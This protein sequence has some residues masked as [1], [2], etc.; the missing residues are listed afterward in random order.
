[1]YRTA[2][3]AEP[4][5]AAPPASAP[6]ARGASCSC[7]RRSSKERRT[8]RGG[9]GSYAEL[10]SLQKSNDLHFFA[11]K[12]RIASL[13]ISS[14][15]TRQRKGL[16]D[17]S[18]SCRVATEPADAPFM[19]QRNAGNIKEPRVPTGEYRVSPGGTGAAHSPLSSAGSSHSGLDTALLEHPGTTREKEGKITPNL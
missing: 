3:G 13:F 16:Q 19:A 14:R 4:A 2:C 5:P 9:E 10:R 18:A 17:P 7:W 6:G 11:Q 15:N 8:S 12:A 1:M